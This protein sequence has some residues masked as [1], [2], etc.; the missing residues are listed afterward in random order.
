ML[1]LAVLKVVML[2]LTFLPHFPSNDFE[3][4]GSHSS[5]VEPHGSPS[6]VI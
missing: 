4:R 2:N 1:N 5:N 3:Q 6:P